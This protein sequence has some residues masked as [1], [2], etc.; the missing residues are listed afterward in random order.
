MLGFPS[1]IGQ[2]HVMRTLKRG[3]TLIE[4]L[5]VIA[6]IGIIGTVVVVA[7]E[8]SRQQSRNT[9]RVAQIKEYQKAFNLYYSDTGHYPHFGSILTNPTSQMCLGDY[10]PLDDY[11]GT[12]GVG[13]CWGSPS[14]WN[15]RPTIANAIV[16]HYMGRI[17]AGET[18][19]FGVGRVGMVYR[20]ENYG[21]SY[22]IMYYMEG[23]DRSCILDGA[24]PTN[25]GPD[26][27]CTFNG[28][29]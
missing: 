11:T 28:T 14:T 10:P 16:P 17:P 8:E 20:S 12:Y 4:L 5:V 3:F 9:A 22:T 19:S 1:L 25:N 6:I 21:K 29:P 13:T 27:L 26:T 7:L 15:E 23:N 2:N 24:I 18:R